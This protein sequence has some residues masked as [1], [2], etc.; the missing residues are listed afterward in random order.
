MTDS[1]R[2]NAKTALRR[3]LRE[4]RGTADPAETASS[5]D[6]ILQSLLTLPEV[7]SAQVV[8]TY[9]SALP[10]EADTLRF[11]EWCLATDRVV[12]VPVADM[13]TGRMVSVRSVSLDDLRPTSWGGLE[14][15]TGEHV[16]DA[17]ADVIIVPGVGFD[18]QCNRLGMGGGFYDRLLAVRKA[19]AIGL[20]HP[21]QMVDAVPVEAHD[22]PVDVVV[23]PD[24]VFR[25][26]VG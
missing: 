4:R 3:E 11:I 13:A 21:W 20:A 16:D 15:R 12:L 1:A 23:T 26:L 5:S 2:S 8:H 22:E 7:I 24:G 17:T 9:V 10:G 14:P 6:A 18:R 19:P 25:R